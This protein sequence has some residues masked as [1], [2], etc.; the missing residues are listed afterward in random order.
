MLG[1]Q[2]DYE[3]VSCFAVIRINTFYNEDV[4]IGRKM[5]IVAKLKIE[6]RREPHEPIWREAIAEIERLRSAI[7]TTLNNNLHL[8]DG[9]NCTLIDLKRALSE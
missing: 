9:E 8:A 2:I 1:T 3:E 6:A 4:I 7:E 5:D